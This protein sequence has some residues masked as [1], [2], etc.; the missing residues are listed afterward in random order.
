M[1]RTEA[2]FCTSL[3]F[4]CGIKI[5]LKFKRGEARGR[6]EWAKSQLDWTSIFK[7]KDST[8]YQIATFE[9][10]GGTNFGTKPK[11]HFLPSV[12]LSGT[13]IIMGPNFGTP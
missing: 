9:T 4:D 11:K 7:E 3:I 6:E 10:L 2:S 8:R 13:N 12:S 5:A 1:L